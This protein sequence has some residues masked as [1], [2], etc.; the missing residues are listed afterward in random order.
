MHDLDTRLTQIEGRMIAH[1]RL[2]ARLVLRLAPDLQVDLLGWIEDRE[3][4]HD[5]QEDPGSLPTE[6]S[7]LPLSIAEEF[8]EI[9]KLVAAGPPRQDD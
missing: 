3:I 2:L 7:V 8:Q 5:G 1:R 9:R 6:L 4:L